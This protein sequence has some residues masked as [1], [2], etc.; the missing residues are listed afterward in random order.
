VSF[1]SLKRTEEDACA[2]EKANEKQRR[3]AIDISI[4]RASIEE[5]GRRLFE[6]EWQRLVEDPTERRALFV[7]LPRMR[8][9]RERK[10]ERGDAGV[11]LSSASKDGE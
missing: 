5:A 6:D 9:L 3:R 2:P 1:K 11:G 4:Q 8:Q 10:K 7:E